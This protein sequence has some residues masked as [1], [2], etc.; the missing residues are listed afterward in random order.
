MHIGF[1]QLVWLNVRP[2]A[3]GTDLDAHF[4]ARRIK[5][6][7]RFRNNNNNNTPYITYH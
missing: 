2:S 7:F 3:C 6:D 1:T 5:T 4:N